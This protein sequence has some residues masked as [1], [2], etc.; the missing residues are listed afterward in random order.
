MVQVQSKFAPIHINC[1]EF[2][3][4]W[5]ESCLEASVG[6]YLCA[7][8]DSLRIYTTVYMLALLM[9]GSVPSKEEIKKTVL[10][11]LQS[12]AFLSANGMGFTLFLCLLRKL[13]GHFNFLTVSAIPSFLANFFAIL[14]ERP[15]RRTLLSL[16]VSNVATETVWN[17]AVSRDWVR[18]RN[19]G[20]VVIFSVCMAILLTYFKSGL[21]KR[22]G[23]R[24]DSMFGVLRF[25][26]GPYEEKSVSFSNE[27]STFYRERT[28][29]SS[30]RWTIP[31]GSLFSRAL[32]IYKG[33]IDKIKR[34][35]SNP[36]CPHPFSC[37]HYALQGF[38]KM[39]GVGL[40][41]QFA[42]SFVFNLKTIFISPKAILWRKKTISLA[43]FLG[44]FTGLFRIV[45]NHGIDKG[46]VPRVPGFNIFLY[47]LSTAIL[48]HTATFEPARLRLSYWSFLHS[49]SAGRFASFNHGALDVWGLDT[50]K[51]LAE[52]LKNFHARSS[53]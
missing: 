16:Y 7:I 32:L 19:D 44:G 50:S 31:S 29:N 22:D 48:F 39:V 53:V 8:V 35:N 17:M 43:L 15:S 52:V 26:V 14:I 24:V 33:L 40:A 42:L 25:I 3:H 21:H 47:C 36:A 12:T 13:L 45:Y 11:M 18:P 27:A 51:Q 1:Y 2:C 28:E 5:T 41:V 38:G 9:K 37:V 4:P 6:S 49:I 20:V 30:S 10:G 46:I 23:E 34:L